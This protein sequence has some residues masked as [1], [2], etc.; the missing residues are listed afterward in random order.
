MIIKLHTTVDY[1][2]HK[3]ARI[4]RALTLEDKIKGDR[5]VI[6]ILFLLTIIGAIIF[7]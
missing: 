2:R 4:A 6:V 5:L 1:A 3:E 7:A